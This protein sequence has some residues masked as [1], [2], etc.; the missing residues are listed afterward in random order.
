[1]VGGLRCIIAEENNDEPV[2]GLTIT[3]GGSSCNWVGR[4]L[5]VPVRSLPLHRRFDLGSD[6]WV[7][8]DAGSYRLHQQL[9][10]RQIGYPRSC[11]ATSGLLVPSDGFAVW[12]RQR[13]LRKWE[14]LASSSW[15]LSLTSS[16]IFSRGG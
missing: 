2:V 11:L 16:N 5:D 3:R 13:N 8:C 14:C 9:S 10:G 6:P 12:G 1:M 7:R 15:S 4:V